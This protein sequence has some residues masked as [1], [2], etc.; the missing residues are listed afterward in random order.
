MDLSKGKD[1]RIEKQNPSTLK[2]NVLK[3]IILF[4]FRI[5]FRSRL[6][7]YKPDIIHLNPSLKLF[8]ILRDFS[9]LKIS[10]RKDIPTLFFIHGWSEPLFKLFKKYK[11][12]TNWFL[13]NINRVDAIVVLASEFKQDLVDLGLDE[14]KIFVLTTMVKTSD[15]IPSKK[16]FNP[17]Y[18]VLFCSRMIKE[19]GPY[20]LLE[21]AKMIINKYSEIQFILVGKGN[22]LYDLEKKSK[23]LKIDKKIQLLGYV[24]E[25]EK[26]NIFK[27]SHIFILPTY[28][29]EGFPTVVLEAMAAGM[30]IITTF[31]AGLKDAIISG[32]QGFLLESMP[33]NPQEIADK[34]DILLK[35]MN[36]L[37]EISKNNIQEAKEKYD[38]KIV[39]KNI[40]NIY[41]KILN[42][43]NS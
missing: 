22:A 7:I 4:Y 5:T 34:I 38:I 9:F 12:L 3:M 10:K 1:A 24:E 8:A 40:G 27:E 6:K 23:Q 19:K 2:N 29:G 15:F 42:L 16:Y 32:K 33:A 14:K 18:R 28:H 31:N 35:D 30:P 37:K 17:P 20:E 25:E 39:T 11:I 21:A 13:K 36:L 43:R 41:E 26:V